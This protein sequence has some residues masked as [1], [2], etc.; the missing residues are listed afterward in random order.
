MTKDKLMHEAAGWLTDDIIPGDCKMVI[1]ELV[2]SI[3][4]NDKEIEKLKAGFAAIRGLGRFCE[5]A[6]LGRHF[7]IEE[8]DIMDD[9][10]LYRLVQGGE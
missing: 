7:N 3:Q 8:C 5:T 2:T 4:A 9:D 1:A 6:E 10:P